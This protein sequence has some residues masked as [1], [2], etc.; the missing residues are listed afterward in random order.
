MLGPQACIWSSH[1]SPKSVS[2]LV[3][4]ASQNLVPRVVRSRWGM[5]SGLAH[6]K[7]YSSDDPREGRSPGCGTWRV[8]KQER[9][10]PAHWMAAREGVLVV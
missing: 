3:R 6:L 8:D 2:S 9:Q 1:V 7:C 4:W 10:P 5:S